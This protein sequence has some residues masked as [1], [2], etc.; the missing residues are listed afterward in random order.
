[1]AQAVDP[2]MLRFR[3]ALDVAY[4]ARLARVVL[5]GARRRAARFRL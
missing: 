1:M 4:G 2:S 5:F 3:Q